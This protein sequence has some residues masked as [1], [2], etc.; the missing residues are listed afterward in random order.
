MPRGSLPCTG[1]QRTAHLHVARRLPEGCRLCCV[2]EDSPRRGP[3]ARATFR[4]PFPVSLGAS[5]DPLLYPRVRS[6]S[7]SS[8]S[9]TARW[10][11]RHRSKLTHPPLNRR[12]NA[13]DRV[14]LTA[15][16]RFR[17]LQTQV[18]SA[19]SRSRRFRRRPRRTRRRR[20]TRTESRARGPRLRQRTRPPRL[21]QIHVRACFTTVDDFANASPSFIVD[22]VTPLCSIFVF[23]NRSSAAKARSAAASTCA[24]YQPLVKASVAAASAGR[25]CR[26]AR[27]HEGTEPGRA[28]SDAT[29]ACAASRQG[30]Y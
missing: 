14:A 23:L 2:L 29:S 25:S 4:L 5:L 28:P 15:P 19:R 26:R 27:S 17:L 7:S 11:L 18:H 10:T 3:H 16:P 22:S 9:Q 8:A 6:A 12:A 24:I 1:W 13:T 21:N 30:T 20:C